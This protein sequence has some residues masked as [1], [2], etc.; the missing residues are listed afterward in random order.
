MTATVECKKLVTLVARNTK[1]YFKD[2]FLFFVSMI[3]PLIL[4]VL[5]AT[6][7][8]NVYIGSFKSSFPEG[9]TVNDRVLEGITGAWLMSSILSVSSV[10]VAFCSNVVMINDKIEGSINDFCVSPVK[11]VTT[12]IAYFISNFFV[13]L[14]VM[15]CIMLIGHIYLACV[16]WYIP[17]GDVFMIIVDIFCGVLFGTLLAGVVESF[18]S[19]Q[20]GLSA[21]ST[22]VSS[23]Y[24]FICGA[25]MPFSQFGEGLRNTLCLLPGTYGVGIMRNHYMS[26]YLTA[27]ADEG[28]PQEALNGIKENFDISIK[29]FGTEVSLGAMYGILLGACAVLLVAYVAIVIIKNKKK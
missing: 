26:G 9:F 7:L 2:K 23:M 20:G 29:V 22:L 24:G 15:L 12:S 13:T 3:T 25:Y 6:F 21:V 28:V 19:S 17:V 8:R 18:I 4:L 10:T 1:C 11:G 27:L 16:G 14:I 5:F